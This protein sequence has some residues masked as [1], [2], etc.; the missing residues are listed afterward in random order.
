[1]FKQFIGKF[2]LWSET[3]N[4]VKHSKGRKQTSMLKFR[5]IDVAGLA[6]NIALYV[7]VGYIFYSII[8]ISYGGV[9][10]WPPVIVPAV[11]AVVFGPL[12]GGIGAAVGIFISDAIFG[13]N[14]L[15]SLLAGV[16]SNFVAFFLIGY[17]AKK[18]IRWAAPVAAYGLA[19]AL[20]IWIGYAYTGLDF[21][22]KIGF[23]TVAI[24]SYVIFLVPVV[25]LRNS[26]W[27]SFEVGSVL[28]MLLGAAII[29]VTVPLFLQYFGGGA[30]FT[31]PVALSTFFF[32]FFTEIPFVLVLGPPIITAINKAFPTLLKRQEKPS[33]Q[34]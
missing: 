24:A 19:T 18:K 22:A 17:I 14:L 21:W 10:F 27:R 16:T 23:I 1:M 6:L 33:E 28:G 32:T 13:N 30:I 2:Y 5:A 31:V 8:P 25:L 15:L 4:S 34:Q 12:V 29:G 26:K 20:F 7:A 3:L 9:R 11:F